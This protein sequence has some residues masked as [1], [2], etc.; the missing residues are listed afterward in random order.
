MAAA[1]TIETTTM[2]K[3]NRR[4]W[5]WLLILLLLAGLGYVVRQQRLAASATPEYVTAP[6]ARGSI[7]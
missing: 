6:V 7:E 3:K 4:W 1:A 2:Q 5:L